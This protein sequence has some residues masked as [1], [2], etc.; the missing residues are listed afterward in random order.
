LEKRIREDLYKLSVE[1]LNQVPL[2]LQFEQDPTTGTPNKT[3]MRPKLK[4]RRSLFP[5]PEA[6]KGEFVHVYHVNIHLSSADQA[7]QELHSLQLNGIDHNGPEPKRV[8]CRIPEED[9][10]IDVQKVIQTMLSG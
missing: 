7:K 8:T 9:L 4:A 3:T 1:G 10:T 2:W 6:Q 5:I